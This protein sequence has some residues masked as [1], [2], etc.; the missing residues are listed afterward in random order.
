M[1]G[2]VL[3]GVWVFIVLT[4]I[5]A[6]SL[7]LFWFFEEMLSMQFSWKERKGKL[8][9]RHIGIRYISSDVCYDNAKHF[10]MKF[11]RRRIQNLFKHLR[12]SVLVQI[13]NDLKS[14]TGH[15]KTLHLRC[16][17]GF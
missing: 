14:L 1:V 15:E 13:V 12:W 11:E 16:L 17:K 7:C 10:S 8:S 4:K 2:V 5:K 9:P 6:M 3:Q